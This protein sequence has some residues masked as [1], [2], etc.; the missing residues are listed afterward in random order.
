MAEHPNHVR[1]TRS[2]H[3][4]G[5]RLV[6]ALWGAAW[7]LLFRPTPRPFHP[8]RRFLLRLFGA[9]L[10]AT[11]RVYP[12]A[13][14]WL[15]SN[16]TMDRRACIGDHVEVYNVDRI[17]I[18]AHATV[19]QFSHLCTATHDHDD[20]SHPLVTS[21]ITL[22]TRSWVAA[23]AFIGPGVTIG[24]GT[25]VGAR[26]AVFED[27]PPWKIAI[28]SPARVHRDRALGPGDFTDDG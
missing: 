14:I 10:H 2:P 8:W 17:I 26:S 22:G 7:L 3:S 9:T 13:R 24:E 19:S 6:R 15:P 16:L 12:S 28:G 27:L 18:G 4:P 25:V 5:N 23:D 11:A 21:P 1:R 20:P